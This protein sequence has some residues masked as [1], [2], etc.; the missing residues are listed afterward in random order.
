MFHTSIPYFF[1]I[2][3]LSL[4]N[5][6]QHQRNSLGVPSLHQILQ[7]WLGGTPFGLS[8]RAPISKSKPCNWCLLQRYHH[9]RQP[10]HLGSPLPPIHP[11]KQNLEVPHLGLLSW[12]SLLCVVCLWTLHPPLSQSFGM[13]LKRTHRF[14]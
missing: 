11:S 7:R 9:L 12:W 3:Y 14:I 8:I 2:F 6:F 4:C 5:V 10:Q 13:P 1:C